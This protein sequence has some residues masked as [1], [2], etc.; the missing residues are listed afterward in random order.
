MLIKRELSWNTA[1]IMLLPPKQKSIMD[2]K[3]DVFRGA[4]IQLAKEYDVPCLDLGEDLLNIPASLYSDKLHFNGE[5]YKFLAAKIGSFL[6]NGSCLYP[7]KVSNRSLL[8]QERTDGVLFINDYAIIHQ[9]S[10]PTCDDMIDGKGVALSLKPGGKILYSIYVE[11]DNTVCFPAAY[12]GKTNSSALT[13]TLDFGVSP[14]RIS[15]SNCF[16]RNQAGASYDPCETYTPPN[17]GNFYPIFYQT[18]WGAFTTNIS[19]IRSLDEKM[20]IIPK[21][22]YHTILVEN[23]SKEEF[24]FYGLDFKSY[25]DV[26]NQIYSWKPPVVKRFLFKDN[27]TENKTTIPIKELFDH[28]R[29][30]L[31]DQNAAGN[32]ALVC[33]VHNINRGGTVCHRSKEP[34]SWWI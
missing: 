29:V 14:Q 25:A 17:D 18:R 32:P 6:M 30:N 34:W 4:L 11:Q 21:A 12:L 7:T 5:G 2:S 22:G 33:T 1:S 26:V 10:H 31:S 3:T 23:T 20:L 28:L 27:V 19:G 16:D 15:N 24:T 9:P 8:I 13:L